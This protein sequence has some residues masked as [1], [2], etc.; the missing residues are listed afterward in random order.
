MLSAADDLLAQLHIV[1]GDAVLN[2]PAGTDVEALPY[3]DSAFDHVVAVF[4]VQFAPR[5][6]AVASELVR[7]CR[8]GGQIGLVSWTPEGQVGELLSIIGR[9]MPPAPE[10]SSPPSLWGSEGHVR[11]LF[12][13]TVEITLTRGLHPWRFPSPAAYMTFIERGFGPLVS[14]RERLPPQ[15]RWE[16]CRNEIL[17]MVNRRNEAGD[18]SLR[19][20]AEY[21]VIVA[22][23]PE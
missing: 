22:R 21:S 2:I 23:K 7:V 3:E 11:D 8:P 4:S 12:G 16:Q 15:G 13:D 6:E 14:A 17:A 5:H 9:Y 20:S 1:P 18:G 19:M 10:S